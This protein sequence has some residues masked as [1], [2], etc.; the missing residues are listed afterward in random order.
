VSPTEQL[1]EELRGAAERLRSG[2][3][4]D[5]EAALLVERCVELASRLVSELESEAT[6]AR[7]DA[8]PE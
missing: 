8:G 7:A 4:D 5:E 3:L 2:E 6:A 1:V